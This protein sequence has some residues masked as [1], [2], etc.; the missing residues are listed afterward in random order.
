[1]IA[2]ADVL[3]KPAAARPG[4]KPLAAFVTD[5][6]SRSVVA[7]AVETLELEGAEVVLAT[8][9]EAAER[10]AR[11]P[12]PRRLVVDLS[13]SDDPLADL[14]RLAEV[15]DAD[16]RL[17]ALGEVNDVNLY[18]RLRGAGADDYLVKP[19]DLESVRDA[20]RRLDESA[21]EGEPDDGLGRII[22][23]VGARGGVGATTV[24][25]NCAWL[26][27]H[28]F[29]QRT[30]LVDLDLYFGSCGLALDL[31][32]GQGFREALENP[33]RIDGLFIER[34]MVRE[35]DNLF[36]LAA[37]DELENAHG[38]DPAALEVLID[39]LRRDFAHIVFDMPR[40]AAKSQ[41]KL[42]TPPLATAL[43]S[44]PSLAG[45]RDTKRL[46]KLLKRDA[47][48]PDV[49]VVLNRVGAAKGGELGLGDFER[50]LEEK[51][52]CLI[53]FDAK[54]AATSAVAGTPLVQA[55]PRAK[56][57]QAMRKLACRLSAAEAAK[58]ESSPLRRLFG[59]GG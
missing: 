37:E 31:E 35:S 38:F 51:V 55:A 27:A 33:E 52:S 32:P 40:F 11:M 28:E 8:L 15:C 6:D 23:V 18:R 49:A 44:D 42:F 53:P 2:L 48:T 3:P 41:I 22:A 56:P 4:S 57:S 12:T 30:A 46:A 17:L 20:L 26:I 47:A 10:L 59:R 34:A 45:L 1:M 9:G 24:A 21:A 25:V 58:V 50:G 54:A 43:V 39:H 13:A 7:A 29:G 14:G 36:V 5:A 19:L 16:T